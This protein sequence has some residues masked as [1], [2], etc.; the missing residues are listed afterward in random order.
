MEKGYV[1][2]INVYMNIFINV[3]FIT[4][5][6]EH[7]EMNVVTEQI[8]KHQK[9]INNCFNLINRFTYQPFLIDMYIINCISIK[10]IDMQLTIIIETAN[11]SHKL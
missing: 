1:K 8:T 9:T 7:T 11:N 4:S 5:M 10:M 2:F 6:K 3:V